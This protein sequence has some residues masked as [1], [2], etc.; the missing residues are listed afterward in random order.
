MFHHYTIQS[1][2][3]L[4][5][6]N[7]T[8]QQRLIPNLTDPVWKCQKLYLPILK[9]PLLKCSIHFSEMLPKAV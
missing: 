7:Q 1:P 2:S 8:H 9:E 3:T 6:L 5:S 4:L